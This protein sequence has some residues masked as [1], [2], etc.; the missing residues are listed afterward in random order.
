VFSLG[1]ASTHAGEFMFESNVGK[2]LKQTWSW[3]VHQV[4]SILSLAGELTMRIADAG[5]MQISV[6]S[7]TAVYDYILP[8]Q[9][10]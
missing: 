7:G 6:D 10:K 4:Q 8:A 1:D 5:A 2:K 9:S 3:P